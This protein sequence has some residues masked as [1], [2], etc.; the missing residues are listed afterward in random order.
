MGT[1]CY[2]FQ[3]K[4]EDEEAEGEAGSVQGSETRYGEGYATPN[5]FRL[6]KICLN[7]TSMNDV[8]TLDMSTHNIT[9][10]GFKLILIFIFP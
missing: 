8:L 6:N 9:W 3:K 2:Y 1:W 4:D 7:Q 10:N 5:P